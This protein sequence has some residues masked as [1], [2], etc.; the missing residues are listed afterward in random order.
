Q[1]GR[2]FREV[3]REAGV[4]DPRWSYDAELVDFDEDG[5]LDIYVVNDFAENA[6][7]RNLLKETGQLRFR[8]VAREV[9][10]TRLGF[11]MGVSFGDYNNDGRLDIHATYLSSTATDRVLRLFPPAEGLPPELLRMV[12]GNGLYANLGNGTFR[13]VTDSVGP[14]PAGWAWGGG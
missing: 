7:Y 6:L 8:N 10:A 12:A 1:G 3:A 5:A 9:G 4:D 11:G 2:R 14:F 13:E